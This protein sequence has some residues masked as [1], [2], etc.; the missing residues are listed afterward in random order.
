MMYMY[1]DAY[2]I[3]MYM[4]TDAYEIDILI[5]DVYESD[6]VLIPQTIKCHH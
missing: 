3:D 6:I 1:T 2:E 4:Y 5:H